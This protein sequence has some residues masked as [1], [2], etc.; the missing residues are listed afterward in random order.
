MIV[1][2]DGAKRCKCRA[3]AARQ[4]FYATIPPEFGIPRLND[5]QPDLDRHADQATKLAQFRREPNRS[6]FIYGDNGT[7]KTF[8]GWALAVEAF[9]QGRRV[10]AL[11]L[12]K[13]IKQFRRWEFVGSDPTTDPRLRPA[14]MAEDLEQN[15]FPFT[16]FLDE[17]GA[18]KVTEYA[19][20]EFFYVLRAAA[21]FG[22]QIIL[23]CNITPKELQ[24]RWSEQDKFYGDSIARRIA[25]YSQQ[26]NLF[27][28]PQK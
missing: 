10:V 19:A 5:I 20:K 14:V 23:T 7:G 1:G 18:T 13:L 21:S 24:A 27:R 9:E 4:R 15:N 2:D 12:D 8:F 3:E 17:V 28:E 16:V 11:D 25:E 26:V 22:H 6:Y